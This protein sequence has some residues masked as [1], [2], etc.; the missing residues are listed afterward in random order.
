[1]MT[2]SPAVAGSFYPDNPVSL[3]REVESFIRGSKVL[4]PEN[5]TPKALIVPHA[6]YYFSGAV[7]ADAYRLIEGQEFDLV[8]VLAPSHY[9]SFSGASIYSAGNYETPLGEVTVDTELAADLIAEYPGINFVPAAHRQEHSLEVQLPFLQ[10]ALKNFKLLPIVVGQQEWPQAEKLAGIVAALSLKYRLLLIAS[11][12]LSH[13]HDAVTAEFLDQQIV[14]AVAAFDAAAFWSLIENRQAEA[15]GA[16][17]LLTVML[18]AEK[19]RARQATVLSYRHSGAVSGDHNR[20]VG[21]LAAAI[22]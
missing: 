9:H 7:A 20:V 14:A 8:V 18:A 19:L 3:R 17:P 10:V 21:Y 13:F 5:V 6:G 15:C 16:G 11:T 1:M 22:T 12:D 4:V 2:R